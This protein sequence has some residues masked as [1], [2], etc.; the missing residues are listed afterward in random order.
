MVA[1]SPQTKSVL[2]A[3]EDQTPVAAPMRWE[4]ASKH[5]LEKLTVMEGFSRLIR[6]GSFTVR[7]TTD[8]T[9][10]LSETRYAASRLV[11]P[12]VLRKFDS[13]V[14]FSIL[15][16]IHRAFSGWNK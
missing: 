6:S 3:T 10:S 13:R 1:W 4:K 15:I 9:P 7:S 14:T 2:S 12:I 16:F 8:G 5:Q 11:S